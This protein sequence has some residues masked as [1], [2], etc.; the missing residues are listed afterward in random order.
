MIIDR[1]KFLFIAGSLAAS[2]AGCDRDPFGRA[3]APA[4]P[5]APVAAV[6]SAAASAGPISV[7]I[8]PAP[9]AVSC[10]DAQGVPEECPS[11]GPSDEGICPNIIQKRC[12]DFKAAMKPRVAAQA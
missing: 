6:P 9:N 12:T 2:V 11:V 1:T 10:D 8:T 3:P 5:V 7:E 4:A